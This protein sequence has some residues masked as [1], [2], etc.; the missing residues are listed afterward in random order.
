MPSSN[1]LMET[2]SGCVGGVLHLGEGLDPI[3]PLG[4]FGPKPVRVVDRARIHLLVFCFV[5]ERALLPLGWNFVNL[6]RHRHFLPPRGSAAR[7]LCQLGL[8][9]DGQRSGGQAAERPFRLHRK[10]Y[11]GRVALRGD[12]MAKRAWMIVCLVVVFTILAGQGLAANGVAGSARRREGTDDCKQ[13][14]E[15]RSTMRSRISCSS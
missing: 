3:E 14:G 7:A 13:N 9:C 1:H 10:A 11:N 12:P 8:L 5:D 2:L 6:V 4:L 15:I